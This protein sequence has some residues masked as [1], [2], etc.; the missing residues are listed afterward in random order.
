MLLLP[1]IARTFSKS[2]FPA[3][4]DKDA[5]PALASAETAVAIDAE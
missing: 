1:A 5:K 3:A 2:L 4:K